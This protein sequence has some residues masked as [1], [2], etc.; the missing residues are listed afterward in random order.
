M[1]GEETLLEGETDGGN[2]QVTVVDLYGDAPTLRVEW[3]CFAPSDDLVLAVLE[4]LCRLRK[5]PL[6]LPVG[7]ALTTDLR[8]TNPT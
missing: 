5:E 7:R 4:R 8:T 6:A 3:T 1:D 2:W